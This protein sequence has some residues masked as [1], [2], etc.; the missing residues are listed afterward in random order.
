M[1]TN[2]SKPT[3]RTT[4]LPTDIDAQG[5]VTLWDHTPEGSVPVPV[6]MHN[7]DASHALS[8]DPGRW[9]I[10]PF[11]LDEAAVSAEIEKIQKARTDAKAAAE[12]AVAAKELNDFRI[13]AVAIVQ[14]RRAAK[15]A[16]DVKA[17]QQLREPCAAAAI[18]PER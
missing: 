15:A 9:G 16:S 10:E 8:V 6:V 12:A 14:A 18:C 1:S 13:A 3:A 11:D 5:N 2:G 7:S 4:V 17:A